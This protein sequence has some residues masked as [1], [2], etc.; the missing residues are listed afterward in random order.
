MSSYI[1]YNIEPA[2]W[3]TVKAKAKQDGLA[4]RWIIMRLL[5]HYLI[6]GLPPVQKN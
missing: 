3:K 5:E 2:F 1:I 4:I 6:H